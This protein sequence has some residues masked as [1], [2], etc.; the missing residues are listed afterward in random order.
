MIIFGVYSLASQ[1][2]QVGNFHSHD[3]T[4]VQRRAST[5]NFSFRLHSM[6][7][8]ERLN[9]DQVVGRREESANTISS[10]RQSVVGRE[11]SQ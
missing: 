11:T 5:G 9:G 8:L 10:G 1:R 7:Y 2:E 6:H 3:P 4:D